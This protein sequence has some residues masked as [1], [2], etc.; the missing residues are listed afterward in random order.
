MIAEQFRKF[1]IDWQVYLKLE[2]RLSDNTVASYAHDFEQFIIFLTS[3]F[4]ETISIDAFKSLTTK[5]MRSWL[6]H[7]H[8]QNYNTRSTT[9]AVSSIKSFC[10]FLYE[11]KMI[12][13]HPFL[14]FKPPRIKKTLPRPLTHSQTSNLLDNIFVLQDEPWLAQRDQ[15]LYILIYSVGLRI[16]EALSLCWND[17]E[18][19]E[20]LTIHGKGGKVRQVPL[21][22]MA[23][24]KLISYKNF[25]PYQVTAQSPIFIGAKGKKLRA[26]TAAEQLRKY[27]RMLQLPESLTPHALRHTCA[28]HLMESCEDLRG[29]QELLGH[30]N[31]STTQIYTDINQKKLMN[32]YMDTHPRAVTKNKP[33]K[34]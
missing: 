5:A 26:T 4:N 30:A 23:Y 3:Y 32:N 29:I 19:K 34:T 10:N 7:R 27:R 18:Q 2:L 11:Q 33:D 31:L 16:N 1:I 21:L 9:R 28:T 6:A 24:N 22:P 14:S 12:E 17:I 13:T 15:A 8:Q 20:F 25:I